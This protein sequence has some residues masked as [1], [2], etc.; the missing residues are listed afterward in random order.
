MTTGAGPLEASTD[1]AILQRSG[2]PNL[3]AIARS[4]NIFDIDCAVWAAD[5]YQQN[6]SWALSE[7][8]QDGCVA[9][10][11][12]NRLRLDKHRVISDAAAAGNGDELAR[13]SILRSRFEPVPLKVRLVNRQIAIAV[14]KL[15]S[16]KDTCNTG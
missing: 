11:N 9:M 14:G 13:G 1:R 15:R 7:V 3:D 12:F 6:S 5:Q 4:G 16:Q 10:P 8:A 2:S